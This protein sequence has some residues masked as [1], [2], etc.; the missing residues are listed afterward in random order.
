LDAAKY[1]YVIE[2]AFSWGAFVGFMNDTTKY[3]NVVMD[4]HT[5]QCFDP[6][7]LQYS[8]DAHLNLACAVGSA[9]VTGQTLPTFTGEWSSC[10]KEP[11]DTAAT[12][13][14]PNESQR[15]FMQHY[16]LAQ[17]NA[18]DTGIGWF[19]WN[20]KTESAPMWDYYVGVRG[21]WLPCILPSPYEGLACPVGPFEVELF[22][23]PGWVANITEPPGKKNSRK[24]LRK[25][26]QPTTST[27]TGQIIPGTSTSTST[28]TGVV[29]TSSTSTTGV[30]ETTSTSTTTTGESTTTGE[31]T[32]TTAPI[33]DVTTGNEFKDSSANQTAV[34]C[35]IFVFFVL[36]SFL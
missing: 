24:I 14:Y 3:Q 16:N 7:V 29:T 17:M 28:T 35:T 4:V 12:E 6:A 20:F 30:M 25:L 34:N 9:K 32:M 10:Y 2:E 19:W 27:T 36:L 13:A 1:M 18:Y 11:S 31:L 26:V 8:D 15:R 5:Y 22:S 21:G 23:C 33:P